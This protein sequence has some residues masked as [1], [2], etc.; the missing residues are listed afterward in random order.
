MDDIYSLL[1][2]LLAA[3]AVIIGAYLTARWLAKKQKGCMSGTGSNIKILER[4]VIGK[5]TY[6]SI[7]KVGDKT[8]LLSMTGQRV[9][10]LCELD[11]DS[12]KTNESKHPE[13]G[14]FNVLCSSLQL[15]SMKK[16]QDAKS[17]DNRD[18]RGG[19]IK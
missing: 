19:E 17:Y 12:L 15:P 5:E 4:A 3:S 10:M 6:L 7:V 11:P 13:T 1:M 2:P 14:F 8:L 16:H 9:E 18:D